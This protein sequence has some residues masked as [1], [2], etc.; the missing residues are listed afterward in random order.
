MNKR[1]YGTTRG[2]VPVY[3]YTLSNTSGMVVKLINFGAIVSAVQVPGRDG[4]AKNV[5]LGFDN[6][7]AYEA[8]SVYFG[9]VAGRYA[10]RIAKGRFTLDG[11]PYQLALNDG[12]NHLH[13]GSRGST[14]RVGM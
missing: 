13:G 11:R 2:G 8:Q 12:P 10:N 9:C 3:E 1:L 14:S 5:A 4:V 6:L 7:A